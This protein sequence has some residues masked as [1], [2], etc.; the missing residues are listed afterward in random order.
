MNNYENDMYYNFKQSQPPAICSMIKPISVKIY[1]SIKIVGWRK[2]PV[3]GRVRRSE[4]NHA[5]VL[6]VYIHISQSE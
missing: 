5:P 6:G 2:N 4:T 3:G 1:K